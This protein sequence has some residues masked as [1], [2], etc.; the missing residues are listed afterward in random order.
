MKKIPRCHACRKEV[1]ETPRVCPHCGAPNP[2]LE[3]D[4]TKKIVAAF[5]VVIL[6]AI[7]V[8]LFHDRGA[9]SAYTPGRNYRVAKDGVACLTMEALGRANQLGMVTVDQ[10]EKL[11]CLLLR[12]DQISHVKI[13]DKN[14]TAL[15]VRLFALNPRIKDFAGWT[16]P[17]SISPQPE[18]EGPQFGPAVSQ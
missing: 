10:A 8:D 5:S 2:T 4:V 14:A 6:A 13:L 16:A 12:P 3:Y 7:A 18:P 9:I 15:K 11:G 17:D 1:A